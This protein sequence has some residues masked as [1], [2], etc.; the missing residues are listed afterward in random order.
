M[1][2][3]LPASSHQM[4]MLRLD[5]IQLMLRLSLETLV[6]RPSS[7]VLVLRPSHLA[8]VLRP[9]NKCLDLLA[10]TTHICKRCSRLKLHLNPPFNFSNLHFISWVVPLS[11]PPVAIVKNHFKLLIRFNLAE[12]GNHCEPGT[13]KLFSVLRPRPTPT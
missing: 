1:L 4:P 10:R 7:L 5:I 13:L 6:L 8:L 9:N 11:Q 3:D 2:L 12:L